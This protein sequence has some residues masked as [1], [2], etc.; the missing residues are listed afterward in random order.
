MLIMT[1]EAAPDSEYGWGALRALSSDVQDGRETTCK[2]LSPQPPVLK[3]MEITGFA[4]I[5]EIY[6]D[7]QEA[8]DS[9]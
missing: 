1:G 7:R 8:I 3:T 4:S 9:F 6:T 5:L 2:F